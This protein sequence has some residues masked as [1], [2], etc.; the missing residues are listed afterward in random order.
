MATAT[1]TLA[2]EIDELLPGVIADRRHLHQHPELGFQEFETSRF[3]AE[4]LRSLGL[5]EVQTEVGRTGVV[6]IL[7]GGKPGKVVALRADMDALPITELNEVD[8]KS[9]NDG[10]M[11]A[12]GHDA[13]ISMLLGAARLLAA[14][15]D[16]LPGTVKFIFQPAEEG[17]GGAKAMLE[18]GALENPKPDAIFGLHIWND[19]PAGKVIAHDHVAMVAGDGFQMTIKGKG[20]HGAQPHT[21]I[22]PIV[23][24]SQIVSALQTIVA[25]NLDP[26]SSGVVTVG[27]LHAGTASNVNPDTAGL[28]G[29]IRSARP[30]DRALMHRRVEEISRGIAE[31][32]GAEVEITILFGVP[33]V[34]NKPEMAQIV[35][36]AVT[37]IF[38]ADHLMNA[39]MKMVSEDMSLFL[40][41]V[42]GCYYFVGSNNPEKGYVYSH[43][44]ARFDIDEEAMA[45]GVGSLAG[46]ARRFLELNAE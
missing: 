33:A 29:T 22:D 19:D 3:V 40:N 26:I 7:K 4:R 17:L 9:K 41:E 13:H 34:I 1:S 45:V 36:D 12:C 16:E 24:G 35:R 42:P 31:A 10:V 23:I 43:H 39:P 11:H 20:G 21:T 6:G 2:Q 25:R 37:D 14:H 15:R 38:G 18:A 32:M 46:S 30:E 5:D 28:R 44:H 8:Y 27:P